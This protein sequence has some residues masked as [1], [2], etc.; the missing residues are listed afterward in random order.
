MSNAVDVSEV[1][2]AAIFKVEIGSV[3]V[4]CHYVSFG[5]ADFTVGRGTTYYRRF[6]DTCLGLA[7]Y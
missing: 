1:Y 4:F 5:Q 7:E 3:A 6:G 2:A